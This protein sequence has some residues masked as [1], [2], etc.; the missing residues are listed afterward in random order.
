[1]L[2]RPTHLPD[3]VRNL[4]LNSRSADFSSAKGLRVYCLSISK[5]NNQRAKPF[6]IKSHANLRMLHART[7]SS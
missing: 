3:L 6:R 1:V 5:C 2:H 7:Q 4:D